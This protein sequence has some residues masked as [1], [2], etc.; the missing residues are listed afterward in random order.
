M[1]EFD[2][3]PCPACADAF[4][5]LQKI[6]KDLAR[7]ADTY[8]GRIEALAKERDELEDALLREDSMI[9]EGGRQ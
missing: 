9:P 3:H 7:T 8:R 1:S 2:F 6:N 5:R 4:A